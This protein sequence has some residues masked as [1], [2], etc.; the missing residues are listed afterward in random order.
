MK[1]NGDSQVSFLVDTLLFDGLGESNAAARQP[2]PPFFTITRHQV[3]P[4]PAMKKE[5][6]LKPPT[7]AHP[8]PGVKGKFNCCDGEK[9]PI[10]ADLSED[11]LHDRFIVAMGFLLIMAVVSIYATCLY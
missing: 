8:L 5:P 2:P 7:H 3:T 9:F 1:L 6:S 4:F 10:F 11:Y